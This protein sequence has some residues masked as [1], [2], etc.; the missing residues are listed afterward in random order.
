MAPGYA[1]LAAAGGAE[2]DGGASPSTAVE[3]ETEEARAD[4]V[5]QVHRTPMGEG[6]R[7]GWGEHVSLF[8]VGMRRY[9]RAAVPEEAFLTMTAIRS[10]NVALSAD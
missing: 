5:W 2:A 4:S 3:G 8:H 7:V 9:L 10:V 6:G 1:A